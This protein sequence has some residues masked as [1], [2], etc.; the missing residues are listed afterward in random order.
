VWTPREDTAHLI[1]C[2]YANRQE[3]DRFFESL[4]SGADCSSQGGGAAEVDGFDPF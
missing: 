2:R 4:Q 3:T 1:S